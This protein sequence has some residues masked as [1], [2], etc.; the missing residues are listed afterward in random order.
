MSVKF[1]NQSILNTNMI[2]T[3]DFVVALNTK[4]KKLE[5]TMSGS[6]KMRPI[7]IRK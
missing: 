7:K 2:Y 4:E 1:N 3:T 5:S 6:L